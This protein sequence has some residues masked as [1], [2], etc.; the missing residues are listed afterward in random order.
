MADANNLFGDSDEDSEQEQEQ[1]QQPEAAPAAATDKKAK[2]LELARNK[3][4]AQVGACEWLITAQHGVVHHC[5][6][7]RE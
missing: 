5:T 7:E 6:A 3:R 4:K 2:L 1:E